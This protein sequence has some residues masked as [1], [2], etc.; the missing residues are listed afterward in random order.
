MYGENPLFGRDWRDI[1]LHRF[2]YWKCLQLMA[3]LLQFD[4][5]MIDLKTQKIEYVTQR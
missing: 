4:E 3:V 2:L 1:A 5:M